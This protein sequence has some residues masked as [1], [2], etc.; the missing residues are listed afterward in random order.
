MAR[1][2]VVDAD[3]L[4]G[5]LDSSDARHER[6]DDLLRTLAS[7]GA[8]LRAS[9]ITLAEVLVAPAQAGRLSEATAA[10]DRLGV[11]EVS[12]GADAA[13][14]LAA[15]R[16]RTGCRLPDCCVLLVASAADVAVLASFDV[17]VQGAAVALG[18][19]LAGGAAQ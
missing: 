15:L 4:I 8:R 2:A 9:T 7:T 18:I 14:R 19:E 6:A 13:Q 5:H 17:R 11:E 3:V 16:A 1:L 10:L 12:F